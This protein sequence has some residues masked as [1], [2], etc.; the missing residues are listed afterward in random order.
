MF[1][2]RA[3]VDTV[4]RDSGLVKMGIFTLLECPSAPLN[5]Y[6]EKTAQI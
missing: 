5:M 1:S 3:L 2:F 4:G 6:A